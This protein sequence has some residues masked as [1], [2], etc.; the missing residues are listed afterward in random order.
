M[1]DFPELPD[2]PGLAENQYAKGHLSG[3]I[4][5]PEQPLVVLGDSGTTVDDV[6]ILSFVGASV[7]DIGGNAAEIDVSASIDVTSNAGSVDNVI[8]LDFVDIASVHD[9]GGGEAVIQVFPNTQ[10]GVQQFL[11]KDANG[12]R[13]WSNNP[14]SGTFV[15]G[16]INGVLNFIS[17]TTC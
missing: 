15:Q 10:A 1:P 16:W 8:T 3:G 5:E 4:T 12:T 17:T 14:G 11:I 6:M 7:Q 9:N 13:R 2:L